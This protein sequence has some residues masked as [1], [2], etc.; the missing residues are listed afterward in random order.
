MAHVTTP[1]LIALTPEAR[2]VLP[3]PSLPLRS[4]PMR[5]GRDLRARSRFRLGSERR[6]GGATGPNDI[7]LAE[8]GPPHRLSREHFLVGRE[9]NRFYV[10]DRESACGT[11][12]DGDRVG[13]A[14]R[15]GRIFLKHGDTIVAGGQHSPWAFR[16]HADGTPPG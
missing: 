1:Y 16:F 14:R 10:E 5:F 8:Q 13:G 2:E 3:E 12:V 7:Y 15:G 6:R 4:L 11:M 9:G